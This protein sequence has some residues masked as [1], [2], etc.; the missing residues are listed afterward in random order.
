[1]VEVRGILEIRAALEH[2]VPGT[3]AL[4][5]D[6]EDV[7]L[8]AELVRLETGRAGEAQAEQFLWRVGE[9]GIRALGVKMPG[10]GAHRFGR[11]QRLALLVVEDGDGKAPGALPRDAPVGPR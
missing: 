5:P 8:L 11:E 1:E 4:E 7:L 6:V 2:R 10:D 9:P 3:A